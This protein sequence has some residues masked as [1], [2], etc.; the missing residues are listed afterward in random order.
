M[1]GWR[2]DI[3]RGISFGVNCKDMPL[4]SARLRLGHKTIMPTAKLDTLA[5][6]ILADILADFRSQNLGSEA[7][8]VEYPGPSIKTLKTKFCVDGGYSGVDFDL[9]LKSL[10][11]GEF[12]GTGP[13]VPHENEPYSGLVMI[14][15][16]S[17]REFLYLTEKGYRESQKAP[18]EK[19]P[20]A[21]TVHISGGNFHNSALAIGENIN[22]TTTINAQNDAEVIRYLTSLLGELGSA[23]GENGKKEV[24]ELVDAAKA[25]DVP[26]AKPI[27]QRLYGAAT[28]AVKGLAWA[29]IAEIIK[30]QFSGGSAP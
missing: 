14:G 11:D 21:P 29:V 13:H 5:K 28:E 9:A 19:K 12:V 30:S 15:L 18:A 27:F 25:G 4:Y 24:A 6:A 22:Q 10:E 1:N 7:L 3:S 16:Y 20:P 26:R 23:G 17:K 2:S 8:D